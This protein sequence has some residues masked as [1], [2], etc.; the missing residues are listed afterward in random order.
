MRPGGLRYSVAMPTYEYRC[1]EGHEFEVVQRM[2]EDPVSSCEVCGRPVQRVFRPVAV[3]FKGS[4][5]YTTDYARKG[6]DEK[7]EA[8][9]GSDKGSG[10][11][12]K[13]SGS[14]GS[15]SGT[16]SVDKSKDK[17][18]AGSTSD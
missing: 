2:I 7:A 9:S 18:K 3:H 14:G 15:E 16:A 12:G 4:G 1:E 11:S 6:K 5:F 17:S 13:E 8:K 10:E